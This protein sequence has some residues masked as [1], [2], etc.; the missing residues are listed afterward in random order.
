VGD[1]LHCADRFDRERKQ[2]EAE[3]LRD[4]NFWLDEATPECFRYWDKAT[5]FEIPRR[6]WPLL[7]EQD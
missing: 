6:D 7:P 5:V 1:V 4:L 2:L 3:T